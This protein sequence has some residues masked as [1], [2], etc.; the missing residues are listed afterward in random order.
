MKALSLKNQKITTGT[1]LLGGLL[2]LVS[3]A[4]L[5]GGTAPT[6]SVWDGLKTQLQNMLSSTWV[7]ALAFIS[8]IA[9][10]WQ[11]AHGR[12]YGTL[13]LVLG[14]LAVALIGPTFVSTIATST[15]P[16]PEMSQ[17]QSP[18]AGKALAAANDV[19]YR[20]AALR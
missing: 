11:L 15:R 4:A 13:S 9:A 17:H 2:I 10:V 7:I 3:A 20:Q 19:D 14:I 1:L 12:G 5:N 8:L 18:A 6:A 16:I